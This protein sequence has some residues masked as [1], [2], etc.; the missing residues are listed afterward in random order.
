MTIR[1]LHTSDVHLGATFR[2]LGERGP[3][4]RRQLRETFGHLVDL[5][6]AERVDAVLIAGDLFDS[7][8]AARVHV[9]F[10]AGQLNR[11]AQAGIPVCAIAGNHDPLGEG[12]AGV[13]AE[14][15]RRCPA[16]TVFGQQFGERVIAECDLTIAGRSA[17]RRLSAD[18]LLAGL[19]VRR[20]TRYFVAVAHGSVERPDFEAQFTMIGPGEIAASAVDYLALGDWHSVQD[21]SAGGV[22]AWYSGAPE[23]IDLDE[24]R[25]GHALLVTIPS[26]GQADVE[27]RRVG[28]RRG[29][30]LVIDLATAGDG[31]AIARRVRERADPDLALRVL[32]TGLGGI[33]S[34]VLAER[35]REDLAPCFFRLDVRD[36]SHLRPD[37]IDPDQYPDHTV[38]GRFVREMREQIASRQDDDQAL[39]EEALAYGVALLQGTMELPG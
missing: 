15:A 6:L 27:P 33:D 7:V 39:A 18:S 35:V 14:L 5:A 1:L 20:Q 13:W 3:E 36:E 21:V 25:S 31:E 12:S 16:V 11:L 2:I 32:F 4:Q 34:R 10:A 26:P 29:E 17:P 30:R 9:P 23:M 24:D 38:I 37:V 8:A 19:P 28:R 22:A